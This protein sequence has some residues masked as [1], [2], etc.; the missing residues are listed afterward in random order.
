MENTTEFID[1]CISVVYRGRVQIKQLLNYNHINT[2]EGVR[3]N[4]IIKSQMTFFMATRRAIMFG[5]CFKILNYHNLKSYGLFEAFACS[6]FHFF[7]TI[8]L[9]IYDKYNYFKSCQYLKL[10]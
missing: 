6:F 3:T 2:T 9:I 8:F 10:L 1:I 7:N 5:F 4:N